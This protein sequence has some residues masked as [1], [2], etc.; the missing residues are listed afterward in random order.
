MRGAA[1]NQFA[2]LGPHAMDVVNR[3]VQVGMGTT[4]AHPDDLR[5]ELLASLGAAVL[6]GN[7]ASFAYFAE[8]NNDRSCHAPRASALVPQGMRW[9]TGV[10][11]RVTSFRRGRGRPRAAARVP[12]VVRGAPG[13]GGEGARARR[14]DSESG[15]GVAARACAAGRAAERV[16]GADQMMMSEASETRGQAVGGVIACHDSDVLN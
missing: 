15:E 14:A 10:T 9:A 4:G 11:G 16:G 8:V 5:T 12:G 3:L 2:V 7:A 1:F 6:R 13:S